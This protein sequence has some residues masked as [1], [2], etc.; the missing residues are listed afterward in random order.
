MVEE[1]KSIR[2]TN[3][4]CE[5]LRQKIEGFSVFVSQC[6]REKVVETNVQETRFH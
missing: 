4:S 6:L 2:V 5:F 3:Y 1:M